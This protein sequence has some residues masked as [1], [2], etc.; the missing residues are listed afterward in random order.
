MSR[1]RQKDDDADT[2]ADSSFDRFETI[3]AFYAEGRAAEMV[4]STHCVATLA[5]WPLLFHLANGRTGMIRG[6]SIK[7]LARLSGLDPRTVRSAVRILVEM[8]ELVPTEK[9]HNQVPEYFLPHKTKADAANRR[10]EEYL[11]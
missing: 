6:A 5:I 10:A 9:V 8:K 11:G 4:E 3:R 7:R 1:K 2:A